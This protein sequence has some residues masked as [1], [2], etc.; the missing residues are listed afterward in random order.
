V[1]H[2]ALA[3]YDG[4]KLASQSTENCGVI[5]RFEEAMADL[6][7]RLAHGLLDEL[8]SELRIVIVNGPRQSGKTTMLKHRVIS[9]R[10]CGCLV[11]G[12]PATF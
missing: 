9:S 8:A 3:A 10:H 6:V 2:E 7:P 4:V 11:A 12:R 5:D 1:V